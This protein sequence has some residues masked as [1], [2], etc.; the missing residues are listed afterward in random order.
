L[1]VGTNAAVG[2]RLEGWKAIARYLGKDTRT[3]LRWV[4]LG[5][6]V[7]RVN[8]RNSSVYAYSD[9]LEEWLRQRS[10][11]EAPAAGSRP[12]ASLAWVGAASAPVARATEGE[13][14]AALR[15]VARWVVDA[16]PA[17]LASVWRSFLVALGER[18]AARAPRPARAARVRGLGPAGS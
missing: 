13:V 10:A 5:L 8:G 7:C 4:E 15:A 9:E 1:Y 17:A 12:A 3:A 11:G 16:E 2:L 6:P 18:E 14:L